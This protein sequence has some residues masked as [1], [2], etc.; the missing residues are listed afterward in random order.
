MSKLEKD[1]L[2]QLWKRSKVSYFIAGASLLKMGLFNKLQ[3]GSNVLS[4]PR[5]RLE[6]KAVTPYEPSR[7][8]FAEL[9]FAATIAA[10]IFSFNDSDILKR[11]YPSFTDHYIGE[12][13]TCRYSFMR[14]GNKV[15]IGVRGSKTTENWV[16]GF[17]TELNYSP[18]LDAKVHSGYDSVAKGIF[19]EV[20][21]KMT[22]ESEIY[23]TGGSMGGAVGTILGWYLDDDG[24]N[25]AKIWAFANPRVSSGEYGHLNIVNVLDLKDPVVFLPAFSLFTRYRHQGVRLIYAQGKWSW[26]EDSWRTDLLTS[27]LFLQGRL[28]V[29]EH[30]KYAEKFF[31]LKEK[32]GY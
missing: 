3:L 16:D 4:Y 19:D 21:D 24:Y 12:F 30:L 28:D 6:A 1:A 23:I 13:N 26:Y 17:T 31:K 29:K 8:D 27:M 5:K 10:K 32:L 11:A 2:K 15:F 25:V 9:E 18:E 20:K 7:E 22:W 14:Q